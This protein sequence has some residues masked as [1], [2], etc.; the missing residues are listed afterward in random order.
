MLGNEF[1]DSFFRIAPRAIAV[2]VAAVVPVIVGIEV[3]VD[4]VSQ[5]GLVARRELVLRTCLLELPRLLWLRVCKLGLFQNFFLG[6]I[7]ATERVV[8]VI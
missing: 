2:F 4:C 7:A 8:I 6:F 5:E 3:S 1:I